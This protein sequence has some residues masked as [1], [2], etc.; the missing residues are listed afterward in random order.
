[1]T[2]EELIRES[3]SDVLEDNVKTASD[4]TEDIGRLK[5]LSESLSKIAS[6]PYKEEA[7]DAVCGI[8]KIAS[9]AIN[10]V[11][12]NV[13]SL[14]K[15]SDGL[16]KVSEIRGLIDAMLDR[17]LIE[18]YDVQE[19]T[20]ALLKKSTHELEVVKEAMAISN[21]MSKNIFSDESEKTA[22]APVEKRQMFEEVI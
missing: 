6:L 21:D 22:S 12:T 2:V 15:K 11:L 17:G 3:C 18:K 10:D 1:M 4:K 13:E 16:E 19:K 9:D 8:M 7:Y 20:A 14:K 5:G